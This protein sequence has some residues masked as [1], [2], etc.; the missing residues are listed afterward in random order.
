MEITKEV[1]YDIDCSDGMF[2]I[3]QEEAVEL[4]D[5]LNELLASTNF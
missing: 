1:I 3:T 4:R 2:T 5:K